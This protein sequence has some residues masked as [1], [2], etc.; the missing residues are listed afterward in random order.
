MKYG[1]Q[2]E[3]SLWIRMG[4]ACGTREWKRT[5]LEETY[6]LSIPTTPGVY[7]ICAS[8]QDGLAATGVS[9]RFYKQLYS[10]IYVGQAGNLRR[11]FAQHVRGYGNVHNARN[12]FRRLDYWYATALRSEL[13][14]LEQ[15]F[16]AVLGPAANDRNVMAYIGKPIPAG[17]V[18]RRLKRS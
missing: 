12:I 2:L 9:G 8:V 1:W 4:M 7:L 14:E 6:G 16:I 15:C 3:A 10:A 11:R 13:D 5:Y 18:G 17:S